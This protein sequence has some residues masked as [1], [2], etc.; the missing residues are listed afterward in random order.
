[1][2]AMK[3]KQSAPYTIKI[4]LT[5]GCNLR[6][7]FCGIHGIREKAGNFKFLTVKTADTIAS[8]IAKAGWKSKL[9]LTMHGEPLMNPNYLEIISILR[10]YLPKNQIMISTNS[11]PLLRSPGIQQSIL[12]IFSAGTNLLVIDCYDAAI[13]A[14]SQIPKLKL[15][16]I[17]VTKYPGGPAPNQRFPRKEKRLILIEDLGHVH[18]S[19]ANVSALMKEDMNKPGKSGRLGNRIISNHVGAAAPRL[20]VSYQQRCARPFRELCTRFDGTV[21]L[22][23]NDWRGEYK[24]GS[25]KRKTLEEIWQGP[26]FM[27]ARRALYHRDRAALTPCDGCDNTSF[28]I[29]LLPDPQGVK[30]LP[31][32][33]KKDRE[34]IKKATRGKPYTVPVLRPWES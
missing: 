4:E 21:S 27:A 34:M 18:V 31:K 1:M 7:S 24:C 19:V 33:S 17:I 32:L 22:C 15:K 26:E 29:G 20:K 12:N 2:I 6:C 8:E 30:T 14:W 3:Y 10:D 5:E 11:L 9:E 16:D 23:C 28:R 25:L 13:K